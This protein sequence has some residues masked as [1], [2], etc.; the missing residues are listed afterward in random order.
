MLNIQ[1]T[2][3]RRDMRGELEVTTSLVLFPEVITDDMGNKGKRWLEITTAKRS[4]GVVV[5][6]AA[7]FLVGLGGMSKI[8]SFAMGGKG[9]YSRMIGSASMRATKAGLERMHKEK[10]ELVGVEALLAEARAHYVK[11][12]QEV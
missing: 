1:N 7:V 11:E 12:A 3:T 9:D 5:T 6:R 2:K 10:I 4:G 8:H